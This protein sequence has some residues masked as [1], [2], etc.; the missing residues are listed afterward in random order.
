MKYILGIFS[1]LFLVSANGIKPRG[2]PEYDFPDTIIS[3]FKGD[4]WGYS[5]LINALAISGYHKEAKMYETMENPDERNHY[6]GLVRMVLKDAAGI[7]LEE[8]RHYNVT[9]FNESHIRPEHR[10][11]VKSF[12]KELYKQG[13]R[14]LLVEGLQQQNKLDS[15]KCPVSKDGP[16]ISEPNYAQLLRYA[17]KLGYTIK[18]YEYL[19]A[20]N[21]MTALNWITTDPLNTLVMTL[22][23]L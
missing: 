2:N 19:P 7:I 6:M 1:I 12:L 17:L 8:A 14:V 22:L 5:R 15:N 13:Y 10:L 9:M 3:R 20:V 23:I 21:G 4:S 11:F 16:F 18:A